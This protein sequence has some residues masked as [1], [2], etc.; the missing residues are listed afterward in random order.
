M[1]STQLKEKSKTKI[2]VAGGDPE[3]TRRMKIPVGVCRWT[4]DE[5]NALKPFPYRDTNL[6]QPWNAF[7]FGHD[8]TREGI[9]KCVEDFESTIRQSA[10]AR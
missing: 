9:K 6:N 4:N 3:E 10:S 8:L 5:S 1:V 7:E 2:L